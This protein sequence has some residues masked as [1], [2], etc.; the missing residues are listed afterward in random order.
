MMDRCETFT[1][2]RTTIP[3]WSLKVSHLNTILCD[4]YES[5]NEQN[6]MCELCTFSQI[7]SHLCFRRTTYD[8]IN[9]PGGTNYVVIFGPAGPLMYLDQ[10]SRYRLYLARQW[11]RDVTHSLPNLLLYYSISSDSIWFRNAWAPWSL[12]L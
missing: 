9:D 7:R 3:L 2:C 6:R 10:I 4:F 11:Q 1:D 12:E 5:P 8:N